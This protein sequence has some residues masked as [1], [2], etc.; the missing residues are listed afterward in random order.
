MSKLLTYKKKSID[1]IYNKKKKIIDGFSLLYESN[2][3]LPIVLNNN[4]EIEYLSRDKRINLRNIICNCK[5]T[6]I[7]HR[8]LTEDINF[9][10]NFFFYLRYNYKKNKLPIDINKLIYEFASSKTYCIFPLGQP[11]YYPKIKK[12]EK[13]IINYLE[14][15]YFSKFY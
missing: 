12:M 7:D 3:N 4:I 13:D 15:Y 5:Y 1:E 8:H 6:S 9:T 14:K 11:H 2:F 10:K